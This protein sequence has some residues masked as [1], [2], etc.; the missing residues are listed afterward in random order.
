MGLLLNTLAS[1]FCKGFRE[2][3]LCVERSLSK[4]CLLAEGCT[5]R[6]NSSL[7]SIKCLGRFVAA[8]VVGL[9]G[10]LAALGLLDSGNLR[11]DMILV[12]CKAGDNDTVAMSKDTGTTRARARG[13]GSCL[14]AQT[15]CPTRRNRAPEAL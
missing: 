9:K 13:R 3:V 14:V 1:G 4:A 15:R 11:L 12:C 8:L 2:G 10:E 5:S 6:A 7:A